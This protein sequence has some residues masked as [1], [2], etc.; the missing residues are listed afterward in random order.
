MCTCLIH[1]CC[2]LHTFDVTITCIRTIAELNEFAVI[3]FESG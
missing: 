1:T 3:E 2:A